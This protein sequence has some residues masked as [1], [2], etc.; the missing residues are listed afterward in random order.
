MKE[1]I[2]VVGFHQTTNQ[3]AINLKELKTKEKTSKEPSRNSFEG[4]YCK[5]LKENP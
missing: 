2:S 4:F 1:S 3:Q 5:P